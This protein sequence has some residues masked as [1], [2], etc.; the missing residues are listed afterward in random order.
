M[1]SAEFAEWMAFYR[2]DPFGSWR[3][4]YRAGT[5]AA[6]TVNSRAFRP[7]HD[8]SLGPDAFMPTFDPKPTAPQSWQEQR[9]V[10]KLWTAAWSDRG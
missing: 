6:A 7:K 3:E 10:L 5:I 2:L 1:S 4:D 9:E 8:K